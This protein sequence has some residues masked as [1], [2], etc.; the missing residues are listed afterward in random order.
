[1][2]AARTMTPPRADPAPL[3]PAVSATVQ[4][5]LDRRHGL[6][7]DG[8]WREAAEGRRFG[9][10]DPATGAALST[11]AE[12]GAADVDRAVAAARRAFLSPAWRLMTPSAR[13]RMLWRLADLVEAHL[14]E[15]A[16][17][18]SLDNGKTLATARLGEVPAA[19]EQFR[20]YAGYATK[21]TGTTIPTSIVPQS[22]G[23]PP[24]RRIHAYTVRE[25]IGVVGAIT[26]WNSPLLMAAMKLAPALA[27][28][29]TLVLKPAEDT[30]L[31]AI[32]L[33]ELIQQAGLPPGVVNVVTGTG[34]VAGAALAAHPDVDKLT[35][36]GSTATGRAIID[37]ARGNLK[38][39]TLELG[40]KSP[41]IVLDDADL[42][43]AVPGVAR[44]IF[45]NAGQVCV[46]GSRIYV[47]RPLH[48]R[49]VAALAEHAAGLRLGHGLD[50]RSQ[51]G[52]LVSRGQAE[53]VERH[54]LSGLEEGA[55]L[56]VG[57][58]RLGPVGT[59]F[60][61]TVM[62]GVNP[63]MRMMRDE[64]FGPVAAITP[65]D[66]I[67]SVLALANDTEYGLAASVWTESLGSAH[68]LSAALRAGPVWI[69]CHSYF[70]PELPKGGHRQSGWGVENGA[71]GLDNYLETKTVCAVV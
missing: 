43:R 29:C 44:G 12:G 23:Q 71:P 38:K 5:F 31:T 52:P 42:D 7:I 14:D 24:G 4:A 33:G 8:Q 36:T 46:A 28:G 22:M 21:L 69:N 61:P 19:A 6:L 62:T 48:D 26:P 60:E 27:C 11:L 25:P 40:G 39:L 47:A 49:F 41:M 32:R 50:P 66:D 1:M 13:G 2:L 9:S 67:E 64:I 16:E 54:V 10:V 45:A 51:M 53:R 70:S 68:A 56:V 55:D 57:G 37:A 17:L 20:F 59:F 3:A 15:L 35:F 34:R 63:A 30:S 65:F 18:E 58:R